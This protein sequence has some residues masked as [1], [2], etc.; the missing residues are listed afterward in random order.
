MKSLFLLGAFILCSYKSNAQSF[1]IV[2]LQ[3]SNT[4]IVGQTVTFSIAL[5][6]QNGFNA[7]IFLTAVPTSKFMGSITFSDPA[8]NYPYSNITLKIKPAIQDTGIRTFVLIGKNGQI[9]DTLTLTL[10]T[11]KNAQWATVLKPKNLG[12][13]EEPILKTDANGDFCLASYSGVV[14]IFH[15]RNQHWESESFDPSTGLP[16]I[17]N[18]DYIYDK[19]GAFWFGTTNGLGKYDGTYTTLFTTSNSEMPLNSVRLIQKDRNGFPVCFLMEFLDMG[20]CAITRYDGVRWKSNKLKESYFQIELQKK[21]RFCIDSSNTIWIPTYSTGIIKIKDSIPEY[22][23]AEDVSSISRNEVKQ[24]TCDKDGD[25]WCMYDAPAATIGFSHFNGTSWQH[26]S[27]PI[28]DNNSNAGYELNIFFIDDNKN[29]WAGSERGLHRYDGTTWTT[30]NKDNSP[31]PGPVRSIVQ[32]KNKNIWMYINKTFYVFNPTGLVD[33]PLAPLD[34]EE[35]DVT[36]N[37]IQLYPNPT[38]SNFTIS[39]GERVSS[40]S[41]MNSLG[42]EVISQKEVFGNAQIDVSSLPSGLYFVNVRTATGAVVKPIVV[43]R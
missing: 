23:L 30:Y 19:N 3:N 7:T 2:T 38:S 36:A 32:D 42:M 5:M 1:T 28:I 24:V 11:L 40:F 13:H 18:M 39:G 33:I 12:I 34:V 21:Q 20:A 25:M 27:S 15:F 16:D 8:P 41:V 43:S 35:Q 10:A 4:I 22:I 37:D 17:Y 31:L 14:S 9:K 29:I 6:P 26:I